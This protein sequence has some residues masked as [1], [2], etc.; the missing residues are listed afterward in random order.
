[1]AVTK[2]YADNPTL[3]VYY[4]TA[5][6]R[7][8]MSTS[9]VAI[10]SRFY[11]TDTHI[12]Y[13]W[14]GSWVAIADTVALFTPIEKANVHNT[15]KDADTA[16]LG[17]TISPTYDYSLFR[18]MVAINA[19][20]VFKATITKSTDTQTVEFNSGGDLAADALYMFDMLVHTGDAVNF[21]CTGAVTYLV[22]R[23]QEIP[24]GV[25]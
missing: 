17:S 20:T 10:G 8:A 15:A 21:K 11:E 6:E 12:E 16:V 24:A 5:A 18:I 25:Q 4:G 1:M 2:C 22:L 7:G 13:V 9:T 19:A 3:M 23:V 14:T